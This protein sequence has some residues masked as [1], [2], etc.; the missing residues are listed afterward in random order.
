M[1]AGVETLKPKAILKKYKT[2]S[3]FFLLSNRKEKT[4]P[5]ESKGSDTT[6]ENRKQYCKKKKK[7]KPSK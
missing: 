3:F 2:K 7:G 1:W 4:Q 5:F 6:V